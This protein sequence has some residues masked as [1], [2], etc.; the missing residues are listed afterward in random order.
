MTGPRSMLY[1]VLLQII[2]YQIGLELL[3]CLLNL[4]WT[5]KGNPFCLTFNAFQTCIWQLVL[6][7]GLGQTYLPGSHIWEQPYQIPKALFCEL[8]GLD[9]NLVGTI[10]LNFQPFNENGLVSIM[11]D[12]VTTLVLEFL[13]IFNRFIR[14]KRNQLVYK[15]SSV[16]LIQVGDGEPLSLEHAM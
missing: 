15:T 9:T 3:I 13:L 7:L 2:Y 6:V 5:D 12:L 14:S 1:I 10:F 11:S 16:Y 4:I 8:F